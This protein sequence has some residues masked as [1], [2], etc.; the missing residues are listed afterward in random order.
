VIAD[1]TEREEQHLQDVDG[2]QDTES[3]GKKY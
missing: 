3:R 2:Q 1:N